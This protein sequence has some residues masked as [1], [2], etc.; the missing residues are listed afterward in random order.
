M[1]KIV[2]SIFTILIGLFLVACQ[3]DSF[4]YSSEMIEVSSIQELTKLVKPKVERRNFWADFGS[5]K[6]V[7]VA[8]AIP[9][10]SIIPEEAGVYSKTNIQVEGV[11]EAD[12]VKNDERYIYF[13]NQN[14]VFIIDTLFDNMY[15]LKTVSFI[16]QELYHSKNYLVVFGLKQNS[17]FTIMVFD[18]SNLNNISISREFSFE[19]STYISSRKIDDDFYFILRNP[20]VYN[21]TKQVAI[22][23][24]YSDSL[25]GNKTLDIS[26]IKIMGH[27][28]RYF[29][30]NLI[31][32]F[33]PL[34]DTELN[35]ESFIGNFEHT[36]ASKNNLFVANSNYYYIVNPDTAITTEPVIGQ[37]RI[38]WGISQSTD[39]YRFMIEDGKLTYK[40][41]VNVMG[42]ILNQFSMDEYDENFRIVTTTSNN[43][44]E[45]WAFNFKLTT[46]KL[47]LTSKVGNMGLEERVYSVRF[48]K[49]YG[50]VVTFR[51]TDPLYIVDFSDPDDIKVVSEFKTPGVSDYL[52]KYNEELLIGVGRNITED[53][54]NRGVKISLFDVSDEENVIESDIYYFD[55]TSFFSNN[56]KSI[57]VIKEDNLFALPIGYG[58]FY[59]FKIDEENKKISL[60]AEIVHDFYGEIRGVIINHKLYTISPNKIKVNDLTS[61]EEITNFY[62]YIR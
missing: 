37:P 27:Q 5:N 26:Q 34:K 23:P 58:E 52:H 38:R 24:K 54:V 17:G 36:Y 22:L 39:V 32:S 12:V 21:E 19:N 31:I 14:G 11:D 6:K 4:I 16:P 1:K 25:A 56:H 43:G 49:N 46:D 44:T 51:F 60:Q 13:A 3:K 40:S 33:N 61:F 62:L 48:E 18:I 20:Y 55:Q 9:D 7:D 47:E 35:I 41:M 57:I 28:R 53:S 10:E 50:Y 59:V 15:S 42:S 30:H 2:L 29:S 45:T 8:P